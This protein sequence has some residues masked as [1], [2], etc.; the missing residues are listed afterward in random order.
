MQ[1]KEYVEKFGLDS[2]APNKKIKAQIAEQLQKDFEDITCCGIKNK[3]QVLRQKFDQINAKSRYKLSD[4]FFGFL[5]ATIVVPVIKREA[6][7]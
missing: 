6:A 5:Y 4:G 7:E 3:V 2:A 1:P